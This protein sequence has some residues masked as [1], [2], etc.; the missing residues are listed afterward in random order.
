M[1]RYIFRFLVSITIL[2]WIGVAIMYRVSEPVPGATDLELIG[3]CSLTY[4][5]TRLQPFITLV[6]SCPRTDP[7]RLWPFP[8]KFNWSEDWWEL[9]PGEMKA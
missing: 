3:R 6:L 9:K 5:D 2:V 8:I 1:H 7:I 4:F